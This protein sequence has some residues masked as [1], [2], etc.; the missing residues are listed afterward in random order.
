MRIRAALFVVSA[1]RF[2]QVAV[3]FPV[4]VHESAAV[5]E[6]PAGAVRAISAPVPPR[7]RR[8]GPAATRLQLGAWAGL[9]T[10]VTIGTAVLTGIRRRPSADCAS[11]RAGRPR[12][13]V[14]A[15]QAAYEG[16]GAVVVG[17]GPAGLA[18]AWVLAKAGNE[19]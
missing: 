1:G 3:S 6:R 2:F 10:A 11:L 9:A 19:Y 5:R 17:G 12:M 14:G 4:P 15:E 8:R 18:A 16:A 7:D 13:Q